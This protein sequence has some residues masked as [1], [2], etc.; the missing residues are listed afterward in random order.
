VKDREHTD[1]VPSQGGEGDHAADRKY[2]EGVSR[3][4]RQGRVEEAAKE[5][6]KALDGDE[7]D[8]LLEAEEEAAS[9]AKEEDP[10]LLRD[11]KKAD[12]ARA[13]DK[14]RRVD[15]GGGSARR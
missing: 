8:E 3:F 15:R 14:G 10:E 4:I 1:D 13:S 9:R 11:Q 2:R 7:E 12:R 5:A 6:A